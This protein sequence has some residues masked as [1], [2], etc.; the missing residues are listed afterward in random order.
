MRKYSYA[1]APYV[2]NYGGMWGVR[3]ISRREW[4]DGYCEMEFEG[5]KVRLPKNYDA[6]LR[7]VYGD[8][9]IPPPIEER[10]THH[11]L[12]YLNLEERKDIEAIKYGGNHE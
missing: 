12:A 2:A 5:M 6:Y 3:E 1:N 11:N 7:A 9:M 10:V 4:F 8:Y